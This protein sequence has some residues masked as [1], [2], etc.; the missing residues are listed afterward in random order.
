MEV[1]VAVALGLLGFIVNIGV[2]TATGTWKLRGLQADLTTAFTAAMATHRAAVDEEIE[3][4]RRE[5]GETG[6]ALRQKIT[7]VELY[8]R[9]HFVSKGTFTQV[10]SDLDGDIKEMRTEIRDDLKRLESKI[11]KINE[12]NN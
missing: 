12:N 1:W 5:F 10:A 11:D 8:V 4:M 2:L 9:D 3:M 6:L 7:D